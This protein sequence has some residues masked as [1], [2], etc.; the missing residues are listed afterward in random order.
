M[1]KTLQ[2]LVY[3]LNIFFHFF[4]DVHLLLSYAS[5]VNAFKEFLRKSRHLLYLYLNIQNLKS[6]IQKEYE[7]GYHRKITYK[8]SS[9]EA[10]IQ[11]YF[12]T[13]SIICICNL[14]N[15]LQSKTF[16]QNNF[17]LCYNIK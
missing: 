1:R 4:N 7:H 12:K 5:K 2:L 9:N 13:I 15:L 11:S 6:L 10:I 8:G 17:S 14:S 3:F 16:S